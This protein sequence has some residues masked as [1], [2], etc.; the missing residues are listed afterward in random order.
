MSQDTGNDLDGRFTAIQGHTFNIAEGMN[1]LKANS[2]QMLQH[3]A[4]IETNTK[5]LEAI[6][7]SIGSVKAGIDTINLKGITLKQ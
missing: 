4:G 5:R 1:I 3:L 7:N 2:S 6:E